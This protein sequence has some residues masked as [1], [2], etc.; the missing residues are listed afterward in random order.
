MKLGEIVTARESF[1]RLSTLKMP[2]QMAYRLL[3][4]LKTV[5]TE[6]E[7]IEKQRVGLLRDISGIADGDVKL[8][9]GTPEHMRFLVE[10][11]AALDTDSD[12]KPA[13]LKFEDLLAALD[14][15]D[16]NILSAAD[17]AAIE[18]FFEA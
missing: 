5:T 6:I 1:Q 10:Y 18:P 16:G 3:K 11:T 4:Y 13:P 17:L 9:P 7:V 15:R 2:P 12:L 14:G 8:E